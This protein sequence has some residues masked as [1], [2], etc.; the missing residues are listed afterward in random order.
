[1]TVWQPNVRLRREWDERFLKALARLE[2]DR[3]Q[4]ERCG[5]CGRI[6]AEHPFED[7]EECVRKLLN[8]I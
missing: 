3:Q 5:G 2:H 7:Y 1:M 6:F 4:Q 8:D